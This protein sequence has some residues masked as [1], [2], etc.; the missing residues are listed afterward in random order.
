MASITAIIATSFFLNFT[1]I[2][3]ILLMKSEPDI[4]FLFMDTPLYSAL[5]SNATPIFYLACLDDICHD[6]G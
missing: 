3:I 4:N 2:L 5:Q 1:K 6:E